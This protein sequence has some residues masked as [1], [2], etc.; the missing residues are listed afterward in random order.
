MRFRKFRRGFVLLASMIILVTLSAWAVSISTISGANVQLAKNQQKSDIARG[1]AESGHE[2]IRFWLKRFAI[3]GTMDESF[4]F[5]MLADTIQDDLTANGITIVDP[6]YDG[7]TITIPSVTLN[8]ET[9]QSFSAHIT[10]LDQQTVRADVTGKCGS[11][12]KTIR[13]NYKFGTRAQSVFDYG[14][15]TKGSLHLSGNI[16]LEGV[17]VSVESD[18]F[19]ES[20][21][22][23]L[24]LSI[25]GNSHIA[26]EVWI[27]N[28]L[29]SVDIQGG[30]ASI[31]GESGDGALDHV[32]IGVDPPEFPIPDPGAFEHYATNIIDS[33]TEL[34]SG[35]TFE[36][37]K[38]AAG[39]NPN[40]NN[41]VTLNGIVFIETPN[42]VTFEGNATIT[43]IIVGNG[44]VNDDSGE[45][46]INFLGGVDSNPIT[47]LAGQEQ[48]EAMQDE[49][50][51][52]LLAPG[53]SLSFGGNFETVNGAIAGNG[54]EFFGNAGGRVNGSVINYADVQMTLSGNSDLSFDRSGVMQIPAGFIPDIVLHYDPNSYSEI[55]I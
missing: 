43:G 50:G 4:R 39:T 33:N 31:G 42:V 29:A 20:M 55:I 26:G 18:A 8:S 40:F 45:N 32:F 28:P 27:G 12:E 7:S 6:A 16:E 5:E 11:I 14:V 53:F 15:A 52:F 51:T 19:I 3:T 34:P 48:F 2:I 37:V 38:I 44:N 10:R 36:N 1:S 54:I 17:N 9:G 23:N 30:Q 21:N 46:Q 49:T 41:N 24:A 47:D 35:A 25:E 13:V 22:S